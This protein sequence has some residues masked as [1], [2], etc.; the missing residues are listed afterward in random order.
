MRIYYLPLEGY[1]ERYTEQLQRWTISGLS[2]SPRAAVRVIQG[3]AL[4][5][6]VN[7]GSVLDAYGRCYFSTT[8]IAALVKAL[9][10]QRL[11]QNDVIYLDDMFTPGFAAI[12][13]ILEQL[14]RQ[15]RPRVYVR[16]HAQSVD[17][18]DFTFNMRHWMR[19]YEQ[20]VHHTESVTILCSSTVHKEMMRAASLEGDIRVVGHVYDSPDVLRTLGGAPQPWRNRERKVIYS[21]RLDAEKQPH[22]FMDVVERTRA[23]DRGIEFVVCT[24]SPEVKSTDATALVRLRALEEQ[25]AVSIKRKCTKPEYYGHLA[26][27]RVQ[28]NTAK[29]DFVS[30]TALEASTFSTHTLAPAFR[31]FPEALRNDRGHLFVPWS[32]EDAVDKLVALVDTDVTPDV[33]WLA[34]AHSGTAERILDLMYGREIKNWW[35]LP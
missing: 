27:S 30:Y 20:M 2:R 21:S 22:F 4:T 13:Y 29:Q 18:D 19:H 3:T 23:L 11:A 32:V 26:S 10:E 35:E 9:Q 7:T 6:E 1:R 5:D 28:L 15:F 34:R 17:P 12:P 33:G 24:G 25:G 8:Q 14:P 31:S 16:N